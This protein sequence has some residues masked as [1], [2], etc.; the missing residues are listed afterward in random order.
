M[1]LLL[2]VLQGLV[3]V[4]SQDVVYQDLKFANIVEMADG[5]YK[6]WV[7]IRAHSTQNTA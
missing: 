2:H 3:Y 1:K 7:D 6:V 4:H 5:T